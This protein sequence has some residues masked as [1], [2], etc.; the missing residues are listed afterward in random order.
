MKVFLLCVVCLI[1]G[2]L[3]NYECLTPSSQTYSDDN[4]RTKDN[5]IQLCPGASNDGCIS[6][7]FN[8]I[9]CNR[10]CRLDKQLSGKED[11]GK[12]TILYSCTIIHRQPHSH[13]LQTA[14]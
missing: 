10:V 12:T 2:G 11:E 9:K 1:G 7:L 5:Y 3:A 13:T 8:I 14:T 4:N 6:V